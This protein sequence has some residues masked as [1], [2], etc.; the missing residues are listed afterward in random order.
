MAKTE[1]EEVVPLAASDA[2]EPVVV[3]PADDVDDDMVT[4]LQISVLQQLSLFI[5]ISPPSL[6][7]RKT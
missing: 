1:A 5:T 2:K 7:Q 4:Y 6:T 3:P